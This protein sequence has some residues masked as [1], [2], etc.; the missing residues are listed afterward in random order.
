[1]NRWPAHERDM[2]SIERPNCIGGG[3]HRWRN[4]NHGFRVGIIDAD[5][6]VVAT[7]G[8]KQQALAILRPGERRILPARHKL[9]R[10]VL[11]IYARE[12]YL[13]VLFVSDT[14]LRRNLRRTTGVNLAR[15]SASPGHQPNVLLGARGIAGG[16]REFAGG[17][18][19]LAAHVNDPG[20]INEE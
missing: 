4:E 19:P 7:P 9:H 1:R 6:G 11:G 5:E 10:L 13:I 3:I 8:N 2:L 12:P 20:A 18:F 16:I 17:I 15:R 14:P